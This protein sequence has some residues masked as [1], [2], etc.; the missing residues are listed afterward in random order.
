MD[1]GRSR[2]VIDGME[3][4]FTGHYAIQV[5]EENKAIYLAD[6]H[7]SAGANPLPMLDSVFR[8]IPGIKTTV[9]KKDGLDVL[10]LEFPAGQQYSAMELAI[11]DRTGYLQRVEY[12]LNTASL[13]GEDMIESPGHPA[14]Y[15]NRGRIEILFTG[16]EHGRFDERIF[17]E[18][19]F[20]TRLAGKYEPARLYKDYHI[21]LASSNL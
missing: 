17:R 12:S 19:N 2:T 6:T 20:F 4:V 9:A 7:A 15:Q 21:Y 8:N 3:T 14:P 1:K 5:M 13:V 10:T 18:D 11:D 16:Y